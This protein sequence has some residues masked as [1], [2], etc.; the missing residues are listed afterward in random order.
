LEILDSLDRSL[1][2]FLNGIHHPVFD[3]I[4]FWAS[5]RFIWIPFYAV[6]VFLIIKKF[7]LESA[8]ILVSVALV[9]V[10]SDQ[11]TSGIMKPLFERFRPCHNPELMEYIH[12]VGRCGGRYGFASSHAA[13]TFGAA[14]FLWLLFRGAYSYPWLFFVWAGLV[15]YSRIY[16]GVHYPGDILIGG[17]I[18]VIAA[19]IVFY[20]WLWSRKIR[21]KEDLCCNTS[22]TVR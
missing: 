19:L 8:Y 15:S 16:L 9:V 18:G 11:F 21:G 20:L 22:A 13:N 10:I 6:L 7:G 17:L 2:V 12:L 4:M 5:D 14:M 1:F 3:F